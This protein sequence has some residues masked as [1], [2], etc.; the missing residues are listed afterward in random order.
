MKKLILSALLIA[1][2]STA[3]A[4]L[5]VQK[6]PVV[7]REEITRVQQVPPV[8]YS[9]YRKGQLTTVDKPGYDICYDKHNRKV[10]CHE[11][12]PEPVV[13]KT[14]PNQVTINQPRQSS[15]QS[16]M[17]P[18]QTQ[19][20]YPAQYNQYDTRAGGDTRSVYGD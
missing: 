6:P 9:Y 1:I 20:Q 7:A 10:S 8:H 3:Q 13:E 11:F 12:S 18:K 16:Q 19:A 17:M 5:I 14:L 15:K 2:C 4:V